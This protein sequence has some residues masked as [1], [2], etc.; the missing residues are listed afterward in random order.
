MGSSSNFAGCCCYGVTRPCALHRTPAAPDA[1]DKGNREQAGAAHQPWHLTGASNL[2]EARYQ[3]E[4]RCQWRLATSGGWL[5]VEASYQV[6]T[7]YRVEAHYQVGASYRVEVHYQV[8]A[9][10][11]RRLVTG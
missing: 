8:E 2:L 1:G 6:E 7:S 11:Q 4:A 3:V 10:Y 5:P 9:S